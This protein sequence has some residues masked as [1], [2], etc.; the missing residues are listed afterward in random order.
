MK[1]NFKI[2]IAFAFISIFLLG[3]NMNKRPEKL[4][5]KIIETT[6]VHGAIFPYDFVN[7]KKSSGSLAQV[8]SIVKNYREKTDNEVILLDN[9][10]LLQGSPV[11]YYFNFE[12]TKDKHIASRVL[13]YM[14]YDAATVGNHDIETGHDVYD[15]VEKEFN[16]PWMAANAMQKNSDRS[17]FTS[18]TVIERQGVKIVVLGLITPAIPKWLPEEIW[19]GMEFQD[20]IES[21]QEWVDYIKYNEKPDVL[22][23]LFHAGVDYTYSNQDE[24]TPFNENASRLVAEKVVGFDV[25]FAG[26]DHREYNLFLKNP[27]GNNVLLLDARSHAQAVGV[28]TINLIYNEE[29]GSYEKEIV[30]E[31]INVTDYEVDPLFMEKF[32]P[33]FDKVKEYV[34]KPI[35]VF[36]SSISTQAAFFG[37]S[38]FMDLVHNIQ[39]DISGA[40]ISFAAPLSFNA[41]INKGEV[42]VRD[43]FNLYRFENLLY[44]IKLTGKEVDNY[45]EYSC[46]L[47]FNQMTDI[48]S[49]LLLYN[50]KGRLK[51]PFYNFSSAEGIRYTVDLTKPVGQKVTIESM[52]DGSPFDLQKE[53]LVAVNSYRGNGGG[54]HLL[55]G[56]KL[57]KEELN[58]RI[59]KSTEKDLRFYMLK[60]IE[61]KKTVDPAKNNSWKLIPEAWVSK[62][63]AREYQKLFH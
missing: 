60:W 50:D 24:N 42:Y 14:Q 4:T 18:Y 44:T 36:S 30:G 15:K 43:M 2:I 27:E 21:A 3:C 39:L 35:G 52:Q 33:D 45:L 9:G 46:G 17:Y 26:H 40:D 19:E 59:I 29:T 34:S 16:F 12:N 38:P 11:V 63:K 49:S 55:E 20:M 8:Y 48:N 51:N 6:D 28:A 57:T 37:D 23:G 53:Y 7:N 58:K 62:A 54:G 61:E 5:L 13:N 31:L 56:V 41:R 25:I 1:V 10:D 47:W 32:Q 22:I